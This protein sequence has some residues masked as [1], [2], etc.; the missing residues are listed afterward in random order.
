MSELNEAID[1]VLAADPAA[2]QSFVIGV[3]AGVLTNELLETV[4]QAR[5]LAIRTLA[6]YAQAAR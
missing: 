1:A 2:G 4:E 3:L 6:D 5:Y